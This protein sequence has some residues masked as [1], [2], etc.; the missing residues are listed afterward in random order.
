MNKG[1]AEKKTIG[2]TTKREYDKEGMGENGRKQEKRK[3][4]RERKK[5]IEGKEDDM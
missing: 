4:R 5:E 3:R 1:K 2:D